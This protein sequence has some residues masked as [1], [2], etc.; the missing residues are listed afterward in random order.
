MEKLRGFEK[1]SYDQFTKDI[2]QS[3][4]EDLYNSI[5]IPQRATSKSACYDL[6]AVGDF[7]IEPG[8]YIKV[9]TG[10]KVYMPDNEVLLIYIRSSIATKHKITLTNNVGVID[11][12]YY[13]N[14][15]NEG[16]FWLVL[17]N[18]SNEPFT[19]NNG[20]RL[21]QAMFTDYKITDNDNCTAERT[22][23]FGSTGK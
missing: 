1:I 13:N 19:I 15:D 18:D 17:K 12:D 23:G 20:D 9:P 7:V 21:A 2:N 14:T 5:E 4:V 16:H 6:K 3:N 22:S 8:E 11:A 10:L